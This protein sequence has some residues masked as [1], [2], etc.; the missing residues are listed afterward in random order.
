[1]SAAAGGFSSPSPRRG[2]VSENGK[3]ST[4]RVG[5]CRNPAVKRQQGHPNVLGHLPRRNA[6]D[7][8]FLG[9]LDLTVGHLPLAAPDFPLLAGGARAE[10]VY[11]EFQ[12]T[13]PA[14]IISRVKVQT[15]PHGQRDQANAS[16]TPQAP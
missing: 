1:M 12:T 10:R 13:R 11:V 16:P 5:R 7:Q 2:V 4:L 6:T 15:R 3:N 14:E 8:Q 9:G